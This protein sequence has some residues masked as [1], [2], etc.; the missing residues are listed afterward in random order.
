MRKFTG[1]IALTLVVLLIQGTFNSAFAVQHHD[2]E[3]GSG[4][5]PVQHTLTLQQLHAQ[6]LLV[7]ARLQK[8]E[9]AQRTLER[10]IAEQTR[11]PVI[12]R[13]AEDRESNDQ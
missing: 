12:E 1:F 4:K 13:N 11:S 2:L 10:S 8:V 5:L 7:I 9:E 6:L 3:L